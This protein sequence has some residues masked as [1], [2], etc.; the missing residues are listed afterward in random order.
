M[1]ETSGKAIFVP[2]LPTV[3]YS[4]IDMPYNPNWRW[5]PEHINSDWMEIVRPHKLPHGYALICDEEGFM[6]NK[7]INPFASWLYGFEKHGNPILG[8]VLIVKEDFDP[9]EG[10]DLVPIPETDALALILD[11]LERFTKKPVS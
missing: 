10:A 9:L 2:A 4:V 8:D 3:T 5:F 7:P 1:N 6:N 11:L